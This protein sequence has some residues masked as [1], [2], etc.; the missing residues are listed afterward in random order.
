MSIEAKRITIIGTGLIG[1]SLGLALKAAGLAGVEIVGHDRDRGAANQARKMGAIDQ[2][3]HNLPRAVTGAGMVIVATPVLAVRDVM[4]QIAPDLAD[5][6]VVTDTA[7]TKAVV[8]QWAKELLPDG[9][10]FVG[11]HPMAGKETQGIEHAEAALFRG[12]A[13]C[14]CPSVSATEAA[15]KSVVGL[16]R[17]AG[18]E[19]LFIDAAEHDQYAAAISHLPLMMSTAL[20]N[21]LR[22]SPSWPDM[23]PMASSGFRDVTRLAS[24]DPRMSHDIWVTNREAVIHWLER[25]EAELRRFRGLLQDA[26]DE[27]LFETFARAQIE[28]ETFLSQ[29]ARRAGPTAAVPEP[30]AGKAVLDLLVGGM[31]AERMRK[32]QKL[33]ELMKEP[34]KEPA[35]GSQRRP[36]LA[37]RIADDVRRDLEKLER[38]RAAK[39][40]TGSHGPDAPDK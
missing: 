35:E 40:P 6:A 28:R 25:I 39:D 38:K 18:A 2:A 5:G 16:A 27:A 33:P 23:G 7:S 14:V 4:E 29:P 32:V 3:E 37:E 19:P 22:S 36:S 13:Y 8:L 21:L 24:S 20:F 26:N 10:N 12:K 9:V 34:S 17:I 15:V 31:L 30:D 1:G 11:G